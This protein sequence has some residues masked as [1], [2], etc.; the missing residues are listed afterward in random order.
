MRILDFSKGFTPADERLER[1]TVAPLT[2]P[3]RWQAA[4]F[5]L[6]PGGRIGMHPADVPQILAVIEGS[7]RANGRALAPGQAVYWEQ[8]EEHETTT[9]DG[10]T[11][12][13]IEGE[14]LEPFSSAAATI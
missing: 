6:E 10:L 11:A 7:A 4:V 5:R 14:G 1:V 3:G 2:P 8:G 9:E 13:I 12:V